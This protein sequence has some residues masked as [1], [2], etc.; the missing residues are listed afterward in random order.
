M[1]LQRETLK[2]EIKLRSLFALAF[3]TIIG[4]GW[5]TVLGSWLSGAGALGALI[6][7][8][9]G[10]LV[11]LVIGLCYAEV[12]TMYPVSGG[13]V[14]YVYEAWGIKLCFAAGWFLAFDYIATTTFEAISVGW[15]LSALFPG[16]GGPVLYTVLGQDVQL[17]ALLVG[18]GIMAVI[19]GINYRGGKSA[20]LFQDVMTFVLLLASLIF[21]VVGLTGGDL[22][23]LEPAFLPGGSGIAIG[24]IFAV[25][26]TTP[27]WYSGFD[28]IPQAMG[29]VQ[30]SA[31]LR[32]L[33]KV[34]ALAVAL[35]IVFY[36]LVILTAAMSLP[37]VELLAFE[38]PVAGA[39]EAAFDSALLGKLVLFAGLCGLITTWNAIFFAATR[40]VFALGRG[41]MIPHQ[42]AGVHKQHG[43]PYVAVLFVGIVGGIGALFGRNAILPIVNTSAAS[44]SFVFVLVVFGVLR[45]RTIR[46]DHKRPYR[47]PGGKPLLY[48]A[49]TIAFG[50]LVIALYEPLRSAQGGIPLEWMALLVWALLGV[51]FWLVAA[52]VR[53]E[54]SEK[55]RR[56]L[57]LDEGE[58]SSQIGDPE[59]TEQDT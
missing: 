12:A 56:W 11:I 2:K 17:W 35:A 36:C 44:L 45:L 51:V 6:A 7:F 33:P 46:P 42:F 47:V 29:E 3:G 52:K 5:I 10:G 50:L 31:R 23:N 26:A 25:F 48:V 4:V 13:E 1:T 38:L 16:F 14:A 32:L 8:L 49:G 59:P 22:A 20:A 19:T 30:E 27:F 54:V 41:R 43:S 18:L 15:V 40:V 21:I 34:I 9:A 53:G 37:R 24:G 39:L 28:T 57:I 55:D 58:A